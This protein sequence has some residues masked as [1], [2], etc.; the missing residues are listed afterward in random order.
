MRYLS[1]MKNYKLTLRKNHDG[2]LDYAHANWASQDHKHSISAYIFQI[3]RGSISWSCQKLNIVTLSSTKAEFIALTHVTKKHC[4][5]NISLQ[6]LYNHLN[7]LYDSILTI[8]LPLQSRMAISNM[9]G[10]SILTYDS[11]GCIYVS[12]PSIQV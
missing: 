12:K 10:P 3:D 5:C 7:L 1:G 9:L 11:V 6:K 4:G 2:L 8:S